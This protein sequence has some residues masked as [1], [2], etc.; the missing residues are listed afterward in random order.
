MD[1]RTDPPTPAAPSAERHAQRTLLAL[2][3]AELVALFTGLGAQPFHA[4]IARENVLR[5]GLL[6]W[7]AMTS[8]PATLRAELERE[9]PILAGREAARSTAA[10]RTTKLLLE[11]SRQAGRAA[12]VETVHMPS[13]ALEHESDERGG[14]TLC[15]STQAG[16][17]I[18]CP[19]CA[20]GQLGLARNLASHEILEQYVRGRAL[21]PLARSVVMGMGEPLLNYANLAVALDAVHDEM[22]LGSRRVT[23]STVGF[24]DRL[25]K[26]APGRPRFQLAISLHT[27]DQEQRDELVPA[28]RGVPIEEVLAAG[29]DWFHE[30]G[31]EVTYEYVLL[32]G[33]N[34]SAGHARR[35]ADRLRGRR[36]SVNL[37]PYNPVSESPYRRPDAAAVEAFRRTLLEARIVATVR[38]SRG[39]ESDAACG[40]LRLR[41][42]R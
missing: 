34:D 25:R 30:T 39:V 29:D 36:A 22:G 27:P 28:M 32:R 20:S 35:L 40:Q 8:L 19:F 16:C 18:G 13:L 31:R 14:A 33:V 42:A 15:V 41:G 2:S 7:N 37:I 1:P 12:A 4:R 6:D 24:P 10:D 11:F 21:G 9:L 3:P 5:K 23:V 26:L 38:W 17:P